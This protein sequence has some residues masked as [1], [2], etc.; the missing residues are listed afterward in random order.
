MRKRIVPIVLLVLTLVAGACGDGDDNKAL[1]EATLQG[2]LLTQ[3]DVPAGFTQQPSED[4]EPTGT[5]GQGCLEAD[6]D[7]EVPPASTASVDFAT[8]DGGR[9]ISQEIESYDEGKATE[10]MAAGK[11]LMERCSTFEEPLEGSTVRGSVKAGKAP[12]LGDE[13]LAF[14]VQAEVEGITIDGEAVAVREG[15]VLTV[16]TMFNAGGPLDRNELEGVVRKAVEKVG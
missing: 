1:T 13:A 16:I 9:Q 3:D 7:K 12:D 5:E 14:S 6:T 8:A 2:Y 15:D 10:A 11:A 4:E